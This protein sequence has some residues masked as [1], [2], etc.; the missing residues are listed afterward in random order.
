MSSL[1][2]SNGFPP[3]MI[4][5]AEERAN[6]V[7]H[8]IGLVLSVLGSVVLFMTMPTPQHFGTVASCAVYAPTL[9]AVY[10]MSTLSH[11]PFDGAWRTYFRAL[12]QG[13]IYLLIAGNC[14]PMA[15]Q[16]LPPTVAFVLLGTM[17][18]VALYGFMAKVFFAHQIDAVSIWVYVVLG[19]LPI[20]ATPWFVQS[21]PLLS[22]VGGLAG[23]LCYTAGTLFL[24]YDNR[25]PYFHAIWHLCVMAG[26]TIHYLCVL[27]F[28]AWAR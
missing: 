28:V 14:T 17:W 20:F 19:W 2:E 26:S 18:T 4:S 25:V 8:A 23:G 22:L 11:G 6:C 3:G 13:C 16:Y 24:K 21:A 12:D 27:F 10:A 1:I 5:H 7:T 15:V 9:I